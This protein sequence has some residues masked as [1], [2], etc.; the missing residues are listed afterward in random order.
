MSKEE[1]AEKKR[2]LLGKIAEL[3]IDF[4]HETGV[5]VDVNAIG[6]SGTMQA[7]SASVE[8]TAFS[9]ASPVIV[10]SQ[11]HSNAP[12]TLTFDHKTSNRLT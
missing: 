11:Y 12:C 10:S 3:I 1:I 5:R 8:V 2:A 6:F 7:A 9:E 4:H